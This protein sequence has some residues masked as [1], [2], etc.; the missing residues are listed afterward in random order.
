VLGSG[1]G[2]DRGPASVLG[3]DENLRGVRLSQAG[4]YNY[5]LA[6]SRRRDDTGGAAFVVRH[7]DAASQYGDVPASESPAGAPGTHY[8]YWLTYDDGTGESAP[9]RFVQQL[10]TG[11]P[12]GPAGSI[13]LAIP[14]G[15][16]G[17]RLRR[18]YRGGAPDRPDWAG[19]VATVADNTAT[20]YTDTAA[21]V[22]GPPPLPGRP[23][24]AAWLVL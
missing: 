20:G 8:A 2:G 11:A 16:D 5:P 7:N 12:D 13:A 9:D 22:G 15:P 3:W 4:G 10:Y 23:L 19:L 18:L 24:P 1:H 14:R 6:A 17:T 21:T